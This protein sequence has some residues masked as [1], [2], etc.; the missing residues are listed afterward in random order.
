[1]RRWLLILNAVF[2]IGAGGVVVWLDWRGGHPHIA[3]VRVKPL[4][5]TLWVL[6][7]AAY[8]FYDVSVWLR[9]RRA[10]TRG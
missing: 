2:V 1:M 5:A 9:R 8:F 7:S 3:G 10:A 6:G 4:A